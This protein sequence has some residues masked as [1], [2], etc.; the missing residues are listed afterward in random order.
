[1]KKLLFIGFVCLF[2]ILFS[3]AKNVY[4]TDF[5]DFTDNSG[6][7]YNGIMVTDEHGEDGRADSTIRVLYTS[8]KDE[9]LIEF[10]ADCYMEKLKNGN[11]KISFIPTKSTTVKIIKGK[12]VTY[13]PDTFVYEIDIKTNKITGTQSDKSGND[14]IPI[15]YKNTIMSTQDRKDE[16]DRFFFR[17]EPMYDLLKS[18]YDKTM[19]AANKITPYYDALGWFGSDGIAYQAFIVSIFKNKENLNTVVRI[20]YEKNGEINIVEYDAQSEIIIQNDNSLNVS[21]KPKNTTVK[22]IKGKS[23]YSPDSFLYILDTDDKFVKGKQ[24]DDN[25]SA[26]LSYITINNKQE[27]ALKFYSEK[28]EIYQKYLK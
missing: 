10:Q 16:I 14:P 18:F 5:I 15:V 7:Q 13:N 4:Y 2:S 12:D 17:A 20:R 3:Q 11:T 23:S 21:I 22:N 1:M 6:I 27:F 25:S 8:D 26:D 9:H 24:S 19:A 28:D